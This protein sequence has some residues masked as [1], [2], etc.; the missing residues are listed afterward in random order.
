VWLASDL[1]LKRAILSTLKVS[2]HEKALYKCLLSSSAAATTASVIIT[3][4]N[5]RYRHT[6]HGIL[7]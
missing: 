4:N 5:L 2:S 1:S 3:N 7:Q 6:L